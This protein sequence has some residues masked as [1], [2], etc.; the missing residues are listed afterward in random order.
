MAGGA[1]DVVRDG[2]RALRRNRAVLVSGLANKLMVAAVRITPRAVARMVSA[3][4]Q[5]VPD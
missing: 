2:M 4:F 3:R 5:H 1:D